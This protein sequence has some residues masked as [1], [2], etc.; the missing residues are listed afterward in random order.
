MLDIYMDQQIL[1][2]TLAIRELL[3]LFCQTPPL[4]WEPGS[5]IKQ[6][7]SRPAFY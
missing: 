3:F 2:S 4:Y 7:V 5:S 6:Y 1:F